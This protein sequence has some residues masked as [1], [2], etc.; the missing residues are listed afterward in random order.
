[1]ALEWSYQALPNEQQRLLARLSVF[2]GGWTLEAAAAVCDGESPTLLLDQLLDLRNA[3]LIIAEEADEAMRFRMLETVREYAEERMTGWGDSAAVRTCYRDW[4]LGLAEQARRELDGPDQAVWMDRLDAE[5]NN[6]QAALA[7]CQQEKEQP[8]A[9]LRLAGALGRFWKVR[10]YLSEG[11]AALARVLEG[12]NDAV[13]LPVRANALSWAGALAVGQN[14]YPA[15]EVY[16]EEC[17][18]IY[19]QLE[20][21]DGL[22]I[23]LSGLGSLADLQGNYPEAHRL[24]E[25]CLAIRRLL[26]DPLGIALALNPLGNLALEQG[27]LATAKAR[28]E[29]SQSISVAMG[30]KLGAYTS[31]Q[32][33]G[34]VAE[35]AG[36]LELARAIYA[37]CLPVWRE[38]RQ[39]IQVAWGLHGV[40]Y[41]AS[42]LGDIAEAR[43]LLIESLRMFEEMEDSQGL[44]LTLQRLGELA[45][46]QRQMQRAAQLLAAGGH[47]LDVRGTVHALATQREIERSVDAV[48]AALGKEAFKEAWAAGEAMTLKEAI[49]FALDTDDA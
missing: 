24:H 9:G 12:T 20:D 22:A 13:A 44:D 18:A 7:W 30:D 6:L 23:V 45:V 42:R 21:L 2:R 17:R 41:A 38:L 28:Y 47:Q 16:Y 33:L 11:R 46:A 15:A 4:Y 48:R 37:E 32:L 14:D 40:G 31:R 10:G 5:H 29:E 35:H 19:R 39:Q 3:A 43:S 49:R 36:D 25:E 26:G 8:E 27:D 34:V 1:V